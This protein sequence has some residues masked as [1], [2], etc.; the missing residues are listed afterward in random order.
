MGTA[1]MRGR[2]ENVSSTQVYEWTL[3]IVAAAQHADV[4]LLR[5]SECE[6]VSCDVFVDGHI[7]GKQQPKWKK[8]LHALH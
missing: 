6:C 4:V 5:A 2:I 7:V 8:E 3:N 1:C